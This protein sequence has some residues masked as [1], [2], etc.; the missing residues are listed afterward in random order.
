MLAE[1]EMAHITGSVWNFAR[2]EVN[3]NITTSGVFSSPHSIEGVGNGVN[4][5]PNSPD[6]FDLN[7]GK[8]QPHNNIAP[9][10]GVYRF[11]RVK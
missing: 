2:Q 3:Q 4:A 7:F 5:T 6:G 9:I 10:Y 8:D 1:G 11:R